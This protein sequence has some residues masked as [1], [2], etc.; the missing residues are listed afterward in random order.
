MKRFRGIKIPKSCTRVREI[1]IFLVV[2]MRIKLASNF[3]FNP[4]SHDSDS[5]QLN[6]GSET[7]HGI[8]VFLN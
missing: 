8:H 3:H 1:G 6:L 5:K 4:R 2:V 7:A